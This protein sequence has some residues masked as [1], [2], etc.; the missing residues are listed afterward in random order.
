MKCKLCGEPGANYKA[1][2][3]ITVRKRLSWAEDNEEYDEPAGIVPVNVHMDCLL[4]KGGTKWALEDTPQVSMDEAV[5]T[6]WEELRKEYES[7]L[8]RFQK[9][10]PD[11]WREAE[12][13]LNLTREVWQR[14]RKY[15]FLVGCHT[16]YG[17][18]RPVDLLCALRRW[19]EEVEQKNPDALLHQGSL[20]E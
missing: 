2:V 7:E 8:I 6:S 15:P 19:K 17:V 18:L 3:I 11:L 10:F 12:M 13:L 1:M 9:D 14:H 20:F 16:W 4:R 5:E